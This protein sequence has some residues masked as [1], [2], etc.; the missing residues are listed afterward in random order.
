[1]EWQVLSLL[2]LRNPILAFISKS[3]NQTAKGET[4]KII[5]FSLDQIQALW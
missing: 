2:H 3:E 1:M 4:I 5:A